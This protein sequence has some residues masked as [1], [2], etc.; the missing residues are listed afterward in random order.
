MSP[1]H[2]IPR[3]PWVTPESRGA[4]VTQGCSPLQPHTTLTG[5]LASSHHPQQDFPSAGAHPET[6]H[7]AE[8]LL[9]A[10]SRHRGSKQPVS[11]EQEGA[12]PPSQHS[13]LTSAGL[14]TAP[15]P[16]WRPGRGDGKSTCGSTRWK[17]I[18]L[19]QAGP[20]GAR[21]C[22]DA[23]PTQRGGIGT[24]PCQT[25]SCHRLPCTSK[26]PRHSSGPQQMLFHSS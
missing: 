10:P 24:R 18:N 11:K 6:E 26:H 9:P 25:P 4:E 20:E 23:Q 13:T 16:A 3:R 1:L 5:F 19:T 15:S 8:R 21:A 12:A 22:R 14:E 2:V 7:S 17:L